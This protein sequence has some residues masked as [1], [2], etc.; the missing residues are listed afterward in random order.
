M[1]HAN[2]YTGAIDHLSFFLFGSR[3]G[4]GNT[5][6]GETAWICKKKLDTTICFFDRHSIASVLA[7]FGHLSIVSRMRRQEIN[8]LFTI[9]HLLAKYGK[10]D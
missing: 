1:S 4:S 10:L 9:F 6:L 7:L 5:G 2:E 8:S 3:V